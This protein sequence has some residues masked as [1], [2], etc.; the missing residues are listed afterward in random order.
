MG[1]EF[2]HDRDLP[3]SHVQAADIGRLLDDLGKFYGRP[4]GLQEVNPPYLTK[5]MSCF[6]A[7][8]PHDFIRCVTH[9][10]LPSPY[11]TLAGD[12]QSNS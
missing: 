8:L 11:K 12:V 4:A 5:V 2:G 10:T 9:R 1:R 6:C 3:P 7:T